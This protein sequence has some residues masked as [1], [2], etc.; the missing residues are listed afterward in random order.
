MSGLVLSLFPGIGIL[1]KAFEDEGFCMVRGP[2]LLWGGDV[3]RFH[4]PPGRFDGVVG[5]SPCQAF[6]RLV[7]IV[8]HNGYREGENLIPE[9]ERVVFEAQPSWFVME[10]VVDAPLPNVPGYSVDPSVCNNRWLGHEQSRLHRFSFGT[11]DGRKLHYSTQAL[12]HPHFE[13]RVCASDWRRGRP[14]AL[15]AGG[16]QSSRSA[17]ATSRSIA[18]ARMRAPG[19][20]SE[21][22]RA[23]PIHAQGQRRDA[24]QR[25]ALPARP[26]ARSRGARGH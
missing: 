2:D 11:R 19:S 10:N 23:F 9:F 7:H 26:C 5:G 13:F 12:E 8:R 17:I 22:L 24:W 1:D 6:S 16:N 15:R 20:P 3:K 4:V 21:F 18:G 25:R 14:V